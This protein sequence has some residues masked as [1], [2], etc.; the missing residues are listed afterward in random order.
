MA[1][2]VFVPLT[3]ELLYEHPELIAGPIIP[4]KPSRP[5]HRW[6]KQTSMQ[7][8]KVTKPARRLTQRAS[9]TSIPAYAV[10]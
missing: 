10:I 8:P 9:T 4:Y 2:L 1:K 6:S 3:D 5:C 7:E